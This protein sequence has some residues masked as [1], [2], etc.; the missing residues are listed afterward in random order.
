MT[1]KASG[2]RD[3]PFQVSSDSFAKPGEWLARKNVALMKQRLA[4]CE[5]HECEATMRRQLADEESIL[6]R[7]LGVTEGTMSR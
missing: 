4:G 7:I 1:T 5:H 6:S 3:I 2:K